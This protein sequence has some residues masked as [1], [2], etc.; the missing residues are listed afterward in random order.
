M[1]R[2]R[3]VRQTKDTANGAS[4]D[5]AI[6]QTGVR[7]RLLL[8]PEGR[9]GAPLAQPGPP[10]WLF[11]VVG[12]LV[13][14]A[15]G[16]LVFQIAYA[17]RVYPGVSTLGVPLG[18]DTFAEAS[19]AL[20]PRVRLLTD[21]VLVLRGVEREW[22]LTAHD[23][24]ARLDAKALAAQALAHGREGSLPARLSL[25]VRGLFGESTELPVASAFDR[26]ALQSQLQH[27]A[28]EIDR[29]AIDAS[30]SIEPDRTIAQSPS[31]IGRQL[32]QPA[33]EQRVLGA[34]VD[35]RQGEVAL[36]V[37]ETPPRTTEAH[38]GAA[39]T[40]AERVL[41]STFVLRG[42]VKTWELSRPEIAA[43][44]SI[45]QPPG[46]P[47]SLLVDETPLRVLVRRAA[48][49]LNQEVR[50]ARLELKP[51]LSLELT[52]A[53]VGRAVDVD[54][55]V[56]NAWASLA[57]GRGSADLVVNETPPLTADDMR[58]G[59]YQAATQML[60]A[61]LAV[62]FGPQRWALG[63]EDIAQLLRFHGG[64]GET[65]T[66]EADPDGLRA[67]LKDIAAE[68]HRDSKNARFGWE[69]GHLSVLEESA[70][71]R[72]LNEETALSQIHAYLNST[73]RT[74]QL[75]VDVVPPPVPTS[76][77]DTLEIKEPV[78]S[79]Q[80]SFAGAIPEKAH[81][82]KLAAQR[83]NGVVVPAG[84]LFSFNKEVGPTTLD[85]GFEWGFGLESGNGG[86]K[87]I[88][89]VAGGICQVATTLFQPVF[90]SGYQIEERHWHLY[91][92]PAYTSHGAVGLDATVD[93]DARLDFQFTNNTSD[94]LLIQAWTQG[95]DL[96]FAI[97]GTKPRWQVKVEGPVVTNVVKPDETPVTQEDSTLPWGKKI[98]VQTARDGFDSLLVRTVTDGANTRVLKLSSKYEPGRNITL[99]GTRG[100]PPEAPGPTSQPP[101]DQNAPQPS[102]PGSQPPSDPNRPV[103]DG[104][105]EQPHQ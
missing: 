31:Q 77:V 5:G 33:S 78:D 40:A 37:V 61:G 36:L 63:R 15:S 7:Q 4:A 100:R 49:E 74:L 84:G 41:G 62:E 85:A 25:Q 12:L 35:A 44:L 46:Q 103:G 16:L 24:G 80:T 8:G 93:A 91:W 51:D 59:A 56:R 86:V 14:L 99:E 20:S 97:F 65:M 19:A 69:G 39:R 30:L 72:D 75:P 102:P 94:P 11:A 10:R 82:I 22:R 38:L 42:G 90:W 67:W 53:R 55:S 79:G 89:S 3:S 73:D 18:G 83:L 70:A 88:P 23:L 104:Q 45:D 27:F 17:G 98:L 92:I 96:H 101:A 52:H 57:D 76:A 2:V 54:A 47:A 1:D 32:D 64:P 6:A 60:S 71:G 13:V 34:L 87:T 43:M 9:R 81:N 28:D 48:S 26:S 50:E 58:R 105:S 29:P 68:I 95:D 21:R 66:V